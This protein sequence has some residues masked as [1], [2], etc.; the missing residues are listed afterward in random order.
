MFSWIIVGGILGLL[1]DYCRGY[2]RSEKEGFLNE[3]VWEK[4]GKISY[5]SRHIAKKSIISMIYMTGGVR[6][7]L[8]R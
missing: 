3:S 5:G 6:H 4:N 8:T 7:H 1:W 2:L